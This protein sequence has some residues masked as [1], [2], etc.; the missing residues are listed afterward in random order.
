MKI[1]IANW[2]NQKEGF[3]GQETYFSDLSEILGARTIS[4][5]TAEKVIRYNLF[6]D[7]FRVVYRGYIIEKYLETYEKLF[8]PDL[9]IRNSAV[10]GFAKLKTPQIIIFQD[11]YYSIS[12]KLIEKKL[13]SSQLEHYYACMELQRRTAKQGVRVAVSNF[14]KKDME[15][16]GIKCDKV[17]EEGIDIEKFKP[18]NKGELKKTHNIPQDKKV[19]IAVTKFTST[20][21]WDILAKLIN[22][23]SDI[24]WIAIFTEEVG[25]KPKLKN[26]AVA[27]KVDPSLMPEFYNLADFYINT[28]PIESFGL[29][30]VEAASCN[31][32]IITYKTGFAWDWWDK[33][34]G[35]RV[36]KWD[37]KSFEKAV[38][39]LFNNKI[40]Y[41][42]RKAIIEKGFT[43]DRMAKG[44]KEFIEKIKKK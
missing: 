15:L 36:D 10:G 43:K 44:W 6:S 25:C 40:K 4:Y 8:K 38:N 27:E 24:Y 23:F 18:I 37:Y 29:S 2:R 22:K 12:K 9:I 28:S 13:F 7:P 32:P 31:L 26:V 33:R 41:D 30:A 3:G 35:I 20:K 17:I 19:G 34:I 5:L 11:P 14:M 16:C 42:P 21:G 39:N 1:I